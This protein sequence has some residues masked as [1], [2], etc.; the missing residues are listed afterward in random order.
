MVASASHQ[1]TALMPFLLASVA[2][3]MVCIR[4]S[5]LAFSR[6]KPLRVAEAV[7]LR[8]RL[9]PPAPIAAP[10]PSKTREVRPEQGPRSSS[11][12]PRQPVRAAVP[13]PATGSSDPSPGRPVESA[14]DD[15]AS[16]PPPGSGEILASARRE[17]AKIAREIN[18]SPGRKSDFRSKIQ[19]NIDRQFDAAHAAGGAWFRSARVEEITTASDGNAR[20]YRIVTPFGAFCRT[21][22]ANGSQAMNTTC[23]R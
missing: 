19:E 3:H 8:L 5:D 23:P 12:R 10:L 22:P 16:V 6:L 14:T 15:L 21:Y 9:L 18:Q 13:K 1:K 4:L 11:R 17:A 2:L 20:V 7:P